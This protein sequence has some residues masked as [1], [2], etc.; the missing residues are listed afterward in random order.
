MERSRKVLLKIASASNK[1]VAAANDY[2]DRKDL[3]RVPHAHFQL[4]AH[5]RKVSVA[6]E[7]IADI[8]DKSNPSNGH[9]LDIRLRDWLHSD[10]PQTCQD[11]LVQM[12]K[13]IHKDTSWMS[14]VWGRGTTITQDKIEEAVDLFSSCK[15]SFHFLFSTDIW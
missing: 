14:W 9:E 11:T 6:C 7:S 3:G 13:L 2:A 1:V 15:A 10:E 5:M 4:E 8:L 12:E